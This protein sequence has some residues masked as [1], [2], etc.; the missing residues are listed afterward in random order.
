MEFRCMSSNHPLTPGFIHWRCIHVD[1]CT[2]LILFPTVNSNKHNFLQTKIHLVQESKLS[3]YVV[4]SFYIIMIFI[5][6]FFEHFWC[7]EQSQDV[8][9]ILFMQCLL[10]S[11]CRPWEIK[12]FQDIQTFFLI[13]TSLKYLMLASKYF[14]IHM[15]RKL[16]LL[17]QLCYILRLNLVISS[18][19]I[20]HNYRLGSAN[21]H[22]YWKYSFTVHVMWAK[23]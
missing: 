2:V 14:M 13:V 3:F 15:N 19:L 18:L 12:S 4:A 22:K 20:Q 23:K 16:G 17:N 10:C 21:F 1:I 7:Y 9:L 8:W 5:Y 11:C 6:R